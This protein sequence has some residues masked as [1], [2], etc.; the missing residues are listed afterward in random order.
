M[1]P[2]F[3][4]ALLAR[5]KDRKETGC[6]GLSRIVERDLVSLD[7]TEPQNAHIYQSS[8]TEDGLR[9]T[10][11]ESGPPGRGAEE[12][13]LLPPGDDPDVN[14]DNVDP[15]EVISAVMQQSNDFQCATP[16]EMPANWWERML[17]GD[18]DDIVEP[19]DARLVFTH[20]LHR[21]ADRETAISV[22][23]DDPAQLLHITTIGELHEAVQSLGA[24]AWFEFQRAYHEAAGLKPKL[25]SNPDNA[26]VRVAADGKLDAHYRRCHPPRTRSRKDCTARCQRCRRKSPLFC[27]MCR[28][29]RLLGDTRR[30]KAKEQSVKL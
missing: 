26:P 27:C 28:G 4:E 15:H 19:E 30:A 11:D 21:L 23:G 14:V 1:R 7:M 29:I 12:R 24:L 3:S 25:Q 9:S 2:V 10:G 8:V 16:P 20:I 5:L 22:G 13:L 18:P 6:S 17:L